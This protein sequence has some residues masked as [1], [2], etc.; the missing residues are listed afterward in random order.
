MKRLRFLHQFALCLLVAA[1]AARGQAS[2]S[3]PFGLGVGQAPPL[4]VS[5]QIQ[6]TKANAPPG[7]CGCFWMYG[8][9]GQI[10]RAFRP[11][12]GAVVDVYYAHNGAVNGTD[13]QLS[14]L[15]YLLGPRYSYRNDT[16][17][18][19]Y[20]QVLAGASHISSNYFVYTS[21]NTYF[22]F[23]AGAGVEMYLRP[24]LAAIPLEANWVH[25][26]GLNGVN[27]RQNNLRIGIGVVYRFGPQ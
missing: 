26:Q 11:D 14:I 13:E 24:K 19:P 8:G 18:T 6:F 15:N 22:A 9:G 7:Q 1:G 17:Y 3:A 2:G 23:Q 4:Q 12:W 5:G 27:K 25:S 10:V 20:G 16:R 21:N